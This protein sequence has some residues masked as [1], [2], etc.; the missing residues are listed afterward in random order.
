MS[1]FTVKKYEG[2]DAYSYAV[3]RA[4]DVKGLPS[5]IFYGQANPIVSGCSR[6]EAGY[7]KKHLEKTSNEN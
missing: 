7:H 4:K 1:K 2:D 3:F 5:P 6:S